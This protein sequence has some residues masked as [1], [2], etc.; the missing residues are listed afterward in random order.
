MNIIED[1]RTDEIDL[2]NLVLTIGSFDGVHLGHRTILDQVVDRAR[3]IDGKAAVLTLRP[4]P[5]AYFSPDDAPPMLTSDSKQTELLAGTG[6]DALLILPFDKNTASLTPEDFV[7]EVIVDACGAKELVVGHDFRFGKAARG[8]YD[9]LEQMGADLGF[10]VSEAPAFRVD[11]IRVSSTALRER[12]QAGDIPGV[13][14]LLGRPFSLTGTVVSGRRIGRTLG[15]PTAN[16]SPHHTATPA[17]GVYCCEARVLEQTFAAAVNIGVAPTVRDADFAIEAFL[18]DFD[19]ELR[20]EDIEVCF[21][22]RLRDEQRFPSK[23]TLV[24]QITLDVASVRQ[25]M[26]AK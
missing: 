8:D 10:R 15:F 1:I 25:I 26:S 20:G 18:L 24:E 9:L 7:Q 19:G 2:P 5:R 12:L 23:E 6:L 13:T 3:R 16:I 4:H 14:Q 21:H 11:G 22:Q 17:S